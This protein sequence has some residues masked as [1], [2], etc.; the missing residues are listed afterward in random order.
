MSAKDSTSFFHPSSRRS[1]I[2]RCTWA[3]TRIFSWSRKREYHR[4]WSW[5]WSFVVTRSHSWL[6]RGHSCVLLKTTEFVL[7]IF[8]LMLLKFHCLKCPWDQNF[9]TSAF[10]IFAFSMFSLPTLLNFKLVRG[11]EV[12]FFRPLNARFR[13]RHYLSMSR[14][15]IAVFRGS[16]FL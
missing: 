10:Y 4:N 9:R 15:L 14:K 5:S 16:G 6:L 11:P 7:L 2:C 8:T 1:L 13:V 12:S 3:V